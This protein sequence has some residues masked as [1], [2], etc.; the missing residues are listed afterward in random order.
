[1]CAG[2][3]YATAM[4]TSAMTTNS[5]VVPLRRRVRVWCAGQCVGSGSRCRAALGGGGRQPRASVPGN[6]YAATDRRTDQTAGTVTIYHAGRYQFSVHKHTTH[7][8]D[9]AHRMNIIIQYH[10]D[11]HQRNTCLLRHNRRRC[12]ALWVSGARTGTSRRC[13]GRY[14]GAFRMLSAVLE[15][16]SCFLR[17][18]VRHITRPSTF[19]PPVSC[20]TVAISALHRPPHGYE[21]NHVLMSPR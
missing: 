16:I 12:R 1:M 17:E 9:A 21:Q 15:E 7:A 10:G 8:Y 5:V 20:S 18:S 19:T 13:S 11:R 6:Y 4:L 14:T 3:Q 2:K